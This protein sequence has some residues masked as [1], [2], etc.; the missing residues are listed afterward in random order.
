MATTL[1]LVAG[2]LVHYPGC[3]FPAAAEV[4]SPSIRRLLL[5]AGG[6]VVIGVLRLP[7]CLQPTQILANGAGSQ[8]SGTTV[9]LVGATPPQTR[10]LRAR[11]DATRGRLG[12]LR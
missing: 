8:S 11:R 5:V 1:G 7:W 12:Y 3:P 4:V 10:E 2:E 9:I 6:C